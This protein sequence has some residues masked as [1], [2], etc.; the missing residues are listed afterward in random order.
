MGGVGA[1]VVD[2]VETAAPVVRGGLELGRS[3]QREYE[4]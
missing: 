3:R 1:E 4:T 2:E